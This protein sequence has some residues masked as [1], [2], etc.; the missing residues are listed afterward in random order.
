MY[1]QNFYGGGA[2][3]V[4][5]VRGVTVKMSEVGGGVIKEA[6]RAAE[7]KINKS[8]PLSSNHYIFSITEPI[9]TK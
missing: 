8:V 5:G 9:Y 1:D 2:G 7:L 3:V 4:D 6:G